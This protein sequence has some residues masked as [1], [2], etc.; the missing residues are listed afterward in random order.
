MFTPNKT[1]KKWSETRQRLQCSQLLGS[2]TGE[3]ITP[4]AAKI[5]AGAAV[6]IEKNDATVF[7]IVILIVIIERGIFANVVF[8]SSS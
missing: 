1:K 6:E 4:R 5:G 2:R 7:T 8:S 3:V